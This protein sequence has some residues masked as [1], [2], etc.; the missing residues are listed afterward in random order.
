MESGPRLPGSEIDDS[1]KESNRKM[2]IY[3]QATK[4]RESALRLTGFQFDDFHKESKGKKGSQASNSMIFIRNLK[5][6]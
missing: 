5:G 4:S 2:T 3:R 1:N 6:K